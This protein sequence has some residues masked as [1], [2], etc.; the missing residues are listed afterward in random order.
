MSP[1]GRPEGGHR[2]AKHEGIPVSALAPEPDPPIGRG[3]LWPA[4][5]ACRDHAL[6][7]G[8][9][10]PI[11][12]ESSVIE[13]SGWRFAVRRVTSLARKATTPASPHGVGASPANPFLPCDP[14]LRVADVGSTHVA[15]LNK[16]PVLPDHLLL[17]TRA[18][19]PQEALLD[20]DDFLA[21]AACMGELDGLAFY[22]GGAT[23]GASQPH[24]H[25]QLVPLPLAEGLPDVPIAAA[26]AP[27][28]RPHGLTPLPFRHAFVSLPAMPWR[29]PAP[30][31]RAMAARYAEL[32]AVAGIGT[33]WVDGRPHQ[34]TPYNLLVTRHWMLV[35]PRRRECCAALSLNALAF[36]GA[37]FVRDEHEDATVRRM[38]PLAL[39]REVGVPPS[40]SGFEAADANR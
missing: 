12:T 15:L 23:A 25:L 7:T 10:L 5:R 22:N 1:K 33:S 32:L 39:L 19:V 8:A 29:D 26:Y 13:D 30:P 36:G 35:V 34:A 24:K 3:T 4:M 18:F 20:D 21:L 14:A 9:L 38:G 16:F 28:G 6:A 27:G 37:L 11:A 2:S 31:A 17:V 40:V